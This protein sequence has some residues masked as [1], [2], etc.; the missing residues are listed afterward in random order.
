MMR[1]NTMMGFGLAF[2]LLLGRPLF[3]QVT[4]ANA[5]PAHEKIKKEAES[6]YKQGNYPKTIE[7]TTQVIGQNQ[8]DD[9][10]HYLRGS[11]EVEE[12]LRRNNSPMVRQGIAD[13]RKAIELNG[14]EHMDY[15]L[16]YLYGM[17]VLSQVEGR[18]EH[19][20]VAIKVA[21]DVL[22]LANITDDQKANVLYQRARAQTTLGKPAEAAKDFEQALKFNSMH[23]G[24][25]L[26]AAQAHAAAGDFAAAE[27][28]FNKAITTF[29]NNPMVYNDRG[30]FHQQRKEYDKALSDFTRVIELDKNAFYAYTNRGFTL[31]EQGDPQAAVNDFDRSLAIQPGQALVYSLRGT[32]ELRQG[33]LSA[34]IADC[35]KV[36]E[37]DPNNPTAKSD[38]GFAL[39][40]A[41]DYAGAAK[42]FEAAT[43]ANNKDLKHVYSWELMSLQQAKSSVNIQQKFAPLLPSDPQK[44]DWPDQ[45]L[46]YQLGRMTDDQLLA[47]TNSENQEDGQA[48]LCEAH[49]FI[50]ERMLTSG[51]TQQAIAHFRKALE[52]GVKHLSAYRG[53][54]MALKHLNVA[55]TSQNV[56]R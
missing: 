24:A 56:P 12:G 31:M 36:V 29:P 34:A 10:A 28:Q 11:A 40:F 32:A 17:A 48:Q 39:F 4:E 43:K 42:Q 2:S 20:E 19:A 53:S 27:R 23:M 52:T 8:R 5:N 14:K 13:A 15:Y 21:G 7:L 47:R 25:F 38:L 18:K 3:A 41:Q 9:V 22:N 26:G 55:T 37:L 49:F 46:A 45:V 16:P 50:G 35:R 54:E 44:W 30:M 51:D 1:R 6:Y 33:K